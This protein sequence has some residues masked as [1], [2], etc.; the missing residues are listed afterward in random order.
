MEAFV[1]KIISQFFP[2]KI[3]GIYFG[4]PLIQYLDA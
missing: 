3:E 1:E 4:S 2:E